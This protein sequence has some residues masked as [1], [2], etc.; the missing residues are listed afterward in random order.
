VPRI[1]L[2]GRNLAPHHFALYQPYMDPA[3]RGLAR[4]ANVHFLNNSRAG[5]DDYADW[6]GIPRE[7]I[8]V[9]HNGFAAEDR[10]PPTEAERAAERVRHGLPADAVVIGGVFR[11]AAEKEPLLWLDA[12]A[13]VAARLPSA[14]FV[15]FGQGHLLPEMRAHAARLG[16]AERVT[17]AGVTD[18]PL[19]AIGMMD[20]FVLTSSGE[21]LPNVLIEA[22]AMGTAVVCTAAGGAP[23]AVADGLTG[24]VVQRRDAAAIAEA[25]LALAVDRA[26]LARAR[27]EG[28][29]FVATKFGM[30]RMIAETLEVYGIDLPGG[31]PRRDPAAFGRDAADQP[32]HVI[33]AA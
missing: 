20:V 30:A 25:V 10:A 7:R 16:I 23:E 13:L 18:D 15:L 28:P 5:A 8:R 27:R 33:G 17:F 3:Y 22:Q 6:I 1:V 32:E 26:A 24:T 4:L 12:A 31:P 9:I 29:R 14:H 2:S 11:F 21:G 19:S